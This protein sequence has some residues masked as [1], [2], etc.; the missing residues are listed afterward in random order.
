MSRENVEL[1]RSVYALIPLGMESRLI[2]SITFSA[3]ISTGNSSCTC[4]PTIRKE[5]RSFEGEREWPG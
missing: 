3:A 5:S 2:R 4:L 1:V